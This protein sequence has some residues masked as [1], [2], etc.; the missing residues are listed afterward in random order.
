M[1]RTITEIQNQII[2]AKVADGTLSSLSSTS[3]TAVWRLWTYV[4]AVGIQV[5]ETLFDAHKAE[6][7]AIIATQ[8]PHTL[9]WY[10]TMAKA[11]QYGDT[12][13]PD[14][15]TY[16]PVR[17]A[18]DPA[19]VVS[20][21]DAVE[22]TNLV[23]VKAAAGTVGSLTALSGPELTALTSYM[24]RVKDAGVRLQVTSGNADNLQLKLAVYYDP[25]VL[26]ATGARLDGTEATPVTDAINQFLDNLPFNGRFIF[27]QM[28]DAV[29]AV[30]GVKNAKATVCQANYA[31]TPYVDI[32]AASPSEYIPD[33]GYLSLDSTYFNANVSY[34][35]YV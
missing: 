34:T 7:L 25:L 11:F 35:S 3:Q 29:L 2:A 24:G 31:A 12:L 22:L 23:R 30:D 14:T 15:D 20:F 21:A 1:A 33:A 6:V 8:K 18:G 27:N 32:L 10:V 19:F 17:A 13:P 26:D 5:H 16:N 28:M 4:Q 9:Q